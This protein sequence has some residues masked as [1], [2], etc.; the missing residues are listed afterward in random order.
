MLIRVVP[1]AVIEPACRELINAVCAV[2]VWT[3]IWLVLIWPACRNIV[4]IELNWPDPELIVLVISCV[5]WNVLTLRE[6]TDKELRFAILKAA[7]L[8]VACPVLI[9]DAYIC[10]VENASGYKLREDK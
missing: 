1:F 3:V 6:L 4:L 8:I 5:V 7:E 10:P 2:T 9:E